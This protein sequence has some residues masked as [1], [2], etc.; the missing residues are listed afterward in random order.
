MGRYDAWE[1]VKPVNMY[2]GYT[3]TG[4]GKEPAWVSDASGKGKKWFTSFY[5]DGRGRIVLL[6]YTTVGGGAYT[7]GKWGFVAVACRIGT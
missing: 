4:K 5:C 6:Y 3:G 2:T 1:H 7:G